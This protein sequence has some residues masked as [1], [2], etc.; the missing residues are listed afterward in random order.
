[1][2]TSQC[3]SSLL[4]LCGPVFVTMF[5][6]LYF[7]SGEEFAICWP[8]F[9]KSFHFSSNVVDV[10]ICTF[11]VSEF[12]KKNAEVQYA[13]TC[14]TVCSMEEYHWYIWIEARMRGNHP[15][16]GSASPSGSIL[17]IFPMF[18]E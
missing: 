6:K 4:T 13:N 16:Q 9:L 3:P 10:V 17:L 5:D 8:F 1:M 11:T 12:D 18:P 15:G 2:N 14:L 7:K